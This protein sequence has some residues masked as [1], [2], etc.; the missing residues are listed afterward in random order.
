MLD[1]ALSAGRTSGRRS[2]GNFCLRAPSSR[3]MRSDLFVDEG[4]MLGPKTKRSLTYF[5][6]QHP[7]VKVCAK[8]IGVDKATKK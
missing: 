6:L 4:W 7:D 8:G 2:S 1:D 5:A 3:A